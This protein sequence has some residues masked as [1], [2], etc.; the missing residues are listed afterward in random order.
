[1]RFGQYILGLERNKDPDLPEN[2]RNTSKMVLLKDRDY[3]NVGYAN[4]FYDKDKGTLLERE[5][6]NPGE[7]F[8]DDNDD[9][10]WDEGDI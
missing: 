10:P 2:E 6:Y 1:M 5:G 8:K 9:L 7:D 4:L 3:G